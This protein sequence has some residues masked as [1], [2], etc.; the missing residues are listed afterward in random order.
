MKATQAFGSF[1]KKMRLKG[2]QSLRKF[3]LENNL[4]PGNIS[5]IERGI[6]LPPQSNEKLIEYAKALGIE[7]NSDEWYDFFDLAAACS[8][9][10]PKDVMND[11]ELIPKLPLV[12]RSLRG[13][14]ITPEKLE[15]L[16][17]LIRRS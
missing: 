16:A 5:K 6:S 14:K 15:Q 12:F 11:E 8:G 13:Q 17:E 2:G 9:K 3:C 4:D 10:I 7:K 1:F